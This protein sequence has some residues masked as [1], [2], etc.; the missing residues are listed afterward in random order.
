M[1]LRYH[2]CHWG[3]TFSRGRYDG[4]LYPSGTPGALHAAAASKSESRWGRRSRCV[5]SAVA[6]SNITTQESC[7]FAVRLREGASSLSDCC[8][9][10]N[11]KAI[12]TKGGGLLQNGPIHGFQIKDSGGDGHARG[13]KACTHRS[14]PENR[15]K[16]WDPAQNWDSTGD[17]PNLSPGH[18]AKFNGSTVGNQN[19]STDTEGPIGWKLNDLAGRLVSQEGDQK[20]GPHGGESVAEREDR[21]NTSVSCHE[22]DPACEHANHSAAGPIKP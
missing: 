6:S 7:L 2:R 8:F 11:A 5:A 18:T 3:T 12:F 14:L 13:A 15:P 9:P 1:L 16:P 4:N 22:S 10:F 20:K 21:R 19:R 17:R